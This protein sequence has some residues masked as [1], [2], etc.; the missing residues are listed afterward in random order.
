MRS[1]VDAN[2]CGLE[3]IEKLTGETSSHCVASPLFWVMKQASEG[4]GDREIAAITDVTVHQS[5]VGILVSR[6]ERI[7]EVCINRQRAVRTRLSFAD[8]VSCNKER[9]DI[10]D[11]QF[12]GPG[13]EPGLADHLGKTVR[14]CSC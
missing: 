3:L 1:Q 4:S 7:K 11:L 8:A 9:S 5:P 6:Q 13:H 10:C 14:K 2:V 12:Q